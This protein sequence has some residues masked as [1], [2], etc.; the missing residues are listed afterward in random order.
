[1][2]IAA[3][4]P[5]APAKPVGGGYLFDSDQSYELVVELVLTGSYATGGEV[6]APTFK[7]LM[8]TIGGGNV[9]FVTF[10]NKLGY[11]FE[12]DYVNDKV[13]VRQDAAAGAPSAELAAAAYPGALTGLAAGNRVRAFV[14]GT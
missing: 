4:L 6:V 3:V 1:M 8:K 7:S 2:P 5:P 9:I 13:Q 11:Y 10:G 14:K 12:Y